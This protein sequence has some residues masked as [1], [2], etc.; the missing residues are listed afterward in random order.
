MCEFRQH[1]R[2]RPPPSP[3]EGR[4]PN[5]GQPSCSAMHP[6]VFFRRGTSRATSRAKSPPEYKWVSIAEQ[7]G[8]SMT[9]TVALVFVPAQ[10]WHEAGSG[11]GSD[12]YRFPYDGE[13]LELELHD[14]RGRG[15]RLECNGRAGLVPA[16]DT[17]ALYVGG[18]VLRA[19]LRTMQSVPAC[20]S[21]L[22]NEI[23]VTCF[24]DSVEEPSLALMVR[25]SAASPCCLRRPAQSSTLQQSRSA[26]QRRRRST[27]GPCPRSPSRYQ[28]RRRPSPRLRS[29]P[30]WRAQASG[31]A[32]SPLFPIS[33]HWR[34][35]AEVEI[36]VWP[37]LSA[38]LRFQHSRNVARELARAK[39]CFR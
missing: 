31:R 28:W 7:D 27:Q 9:A 3:K 15:R 26:P 34:H 10:R 17:T 39:R 2:E 13:A 20:L 32:W 35:F 36:S 37:I 4:S 19:A 5:H 29:P 22:F 14:W 11:D 25:A 16:L 24:I 23:L 30:P 38:E 8:T 1:K 33:E 12:A 18:D 21:N 6:F